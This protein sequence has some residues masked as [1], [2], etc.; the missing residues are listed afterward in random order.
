MFY[1][2]FDSLCLCTLS[3]LHAAWGLCTH[4]RGRSR[5]S[6]P[7]GATT[8]TG[9]DGWIQT[10]STGCHA[11]LG[12]HDLADLMFHHTPSRP[13]LPPPPIHQMF[14]LLSP[15]TTTY[16]H[17]LPSH[18]THILPIIPMLPPIIHTTSHHPHYLPSH[19]HYLP[20]STLPPITPTLPPITPMLPPI[21]HTPSHHTHTP[22]HHTHTHSHHTHTTSPPTTPPQ[23]KREPKPFPKLVLKRKVEDIDD[24]KFED[25]EIVGYKPHPKIAM[26]MAV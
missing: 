15:D 1:M 10:V 18:H 21:I 25:F 12:T 8:G 24:F 23:I 7:R 26:K 22:S 14:S 19:P 11:Y 17:L 6:E 9:E 2:C 3:S 16:L 4:A 13:S 5:V 20:S